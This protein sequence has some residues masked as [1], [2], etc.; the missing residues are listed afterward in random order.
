LR[1]KEK[2]FFTLSTLARV[3]KDQ[4][5]SILITKLSNLGIDIFAIIE[6][7]VSGPINIL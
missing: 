5:K 7:I 2:L 4:S 1:W 6:E 3:E